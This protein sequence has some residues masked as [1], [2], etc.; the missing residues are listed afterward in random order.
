MEVTGNPLRDT[1]LMLA[2]AKNTWRWPR[3]KL[4][5]AGVVFGGVELVY[6]TGNLVKPTHGGWLPL[7]V[8]TGVFT[9]M[10]TWQAGRRIVTANRPQLE[11]PPPGVVNGAAEH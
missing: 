1:I 4:V 5:L 3:W 11:G 7:L 6:L 2:V 10:T 9:V 8:A